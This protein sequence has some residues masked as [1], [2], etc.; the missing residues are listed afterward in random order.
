MINLKCSK[1]LNLEYIN[2]IELGP[3]FKLPKFPQDH[4]VEKK[5]IKEV[6]MLRGRECVTLATEEGS[7]RPLFWEGWCE[8]NANRSSFH[9]FSFF[10][11]PEAFSSFSALHFAI[12]TFLL[13]SQ[14]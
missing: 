9:D 4:F 6:R 1:Y 12:N 5:N 3:K 2:F 10:C 7:I 13:K 8:S 11:P 14:N